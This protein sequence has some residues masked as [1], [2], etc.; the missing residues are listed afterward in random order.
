MDSLL[1]LV[2]HEAFYDELEKIA[3]SEEKKV[4]LRKKLKAMGLT[5]LGTGLGYATASA[6]HHYLKHNPPQIWNNLPI[7]KK[8]QVL[9][10][11]KA[12]AGVGGAFAAKRLMH[13]REKMERG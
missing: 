7:E 5:A 6:L 4:P 1:Y 3:S 11:A 2:R 8:Y 9:G 13:H 12:L 10:A